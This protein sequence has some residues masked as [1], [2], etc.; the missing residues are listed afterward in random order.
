MRSIQS[1]ASRGESAASRTRKVA[2]S[3][4]NEPEG[5]EGSTLDLVLAAGAGTLLARLFD[6]WPGRGRPGPLGLARAAAAGALAALVREV[7]APVLEGEIRTPD[8]DGDTG[9]RVLAGAARGLLYGGLIEPRLP[10]AVLARGLT[11][12]TAEWALSEWGGLRGLLS[13]YTPYRR[14][15]V[16]G[17]LL[18][19]AEGGEKTLIDHLAFGVALALLYD[20]GSRMGIGDDAE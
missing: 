16:V 4:V 13:R 12:G 19:D 8:M 18:G 3:K 5:D 20:A 6:A 2:S 1:L 15:P 7:I 9:E 14:L 10:G 11:Y 17:G